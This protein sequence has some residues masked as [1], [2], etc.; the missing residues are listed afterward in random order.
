MTAATDRSRTTRS[1]TY[2]VVRSL[3]ALWG[4]LLCGTA[5]SGVLFHEALQSETPVHPLTAADIVEA[6]LL[7]TTGL[8]LTLPFR[9][10]ARHAMLLLLLQSGTIVLILWILVRNVHRDG[11]LVTVARVA[12]MLIPPMLAT[13]LVGRARQL[14]RTAPANT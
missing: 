2:F 10:L 7:L 8:L 4:L 12:L 13:A 3:L 9:W 6:A 14:D 11:V 1:I 5:V